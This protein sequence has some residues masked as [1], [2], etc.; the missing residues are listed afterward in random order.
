MV[1]KSHPEILPHLKGWAYFWA[2][3]DLAIKA[4]T[5]LSDIRGTYNDAIVSSLIDYFEGGGI[6]ASRNEFKNAMIQAFGDVFDAGWVE[7][8]GELPV[9]DEALNWI[10]SRLNEEAGYIDSLFQEAKDL[11][12]Q[13]DFDYFSWVTQKADGYTRTLESVY[14]AAVL[15]IKD[16]QMLTWNLGQTEIHCDTCSKL[17][18]QRHRASW[19]LSRNYIPRKPGSS[20]ECGGYNCDCSLT[21]DEGN[22][23][24]L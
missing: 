15:L 9:D 19:Y 23:I 2:R 16:R 24:T 7:G 10:E 8:G 20:T 17:N 21:D 5:D 11:R 18:G 14:N 6:A 1:I 12:K 4:D 13:D 22:E 3:H